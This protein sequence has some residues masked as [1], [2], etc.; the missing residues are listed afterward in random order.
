MVQRNRQGDSPGTGEFDRWIIR[1]FARL[2]DLGDSRGDDSTRTLI[3]ENGISESPTLAKTARMGHPSSKAETPNFKGTERQADCW[4]ERLRW[5]ETSASLSD[6]C[7][8]DEAAHGDIAYVR[9]VLDAGDSPADI[10]L[11]VLE[12]VE[13]RWSYG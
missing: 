3:T 6:F 1:E 5:S 10:L 13:V 7:V 12:G 8:A 11:D 4:E 2:L 9:M